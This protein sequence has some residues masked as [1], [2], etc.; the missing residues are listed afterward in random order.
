[1]APL[2]A[3][4]AEISV[5]GGMLIDAEAIGHARTS[6]AAEMFATEC[7][8][9]V[10]GAILRLHDEGLA[11]D[12]VSVAE[13]L[14]RAGD[15][16]A[17]GGVEYIGRLLDVVP[18][19]ANIAHH[20]RI[21]RERHAARTLVRELETEREAL[22]TGGKLLPAVLDR[23]ADV[24]DDGKVLANGG[25]T[26]QR[27]LAAPFGVTELLDLP[28]PEESN[29]ID[30]IIP[31]DANVLL[32]AYPKCFKTGF[33][34]DVAI[35]A[36]AGISLLDRFRARRRHRVGLV[37]ME[38]RAHRWRRRLWRLCK[39]HGLTPEDL[40]GWLFTWFR[41]PLVLSDP[42]VMAD[43]HAYVQEYKLDLLIVDSWSYVSTGNPNDAEVV[44]PQLMALSRL[45][46]DAAGLSVLLVHHARKTKPGDDEEGERLTDA[47]RNSSAFGAW[48]DAG[49]VLSR[50]NETA[51][52]KVRTE[53]R[54]L[55]ALDPFMFTLE[56]ECAATAENGFRPGGWLRM[57]PSSAP[58]AVVQRSAEV[59]RFVSAVQEVLT[60]QPGCS[61]AELRKRIKGDN[62]FIVAAFEL[63]CERGEARYEAPSK[64]GS[65]GRCFPIPDTALNHAGTA[66]AARL[67][68]DR[69]DPAVGAR[70]APSGSQS[71]RVLGGD[72][73]GGEASAVPGDE[74][75]E[76]EFE[77]LRSRQ[78]QGASA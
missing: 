21:V 4:E 72:S 5:L 40:Q 13:E 27:R 9:R 6:V 33:L 26:S 10:F 70:R 77:R 50:R 44:T 58:P 38:D 1:L 15:L 31:S 3:P 32:A 62:A 7:N 45:R 25:R 53:L 35:S 48:Y 69:A 49:I 63:L 73:S 39:G 68:T 76:L 57:K 47:I 56:D 64:R 30:P 54:D 17:V 71:A 60:A 37:L 52:I 28:E 61:K 67:S 36:T 41:P 78:E 59:E 42:A 51:P 74:E 11:A 75:Y 8:R 19:A 46:E 43:L 16:E 14:R 66:L 12:V 2:Y 65:G 22:L 55:P 24:L 29:I 34:S 23:L 20:A 18:T